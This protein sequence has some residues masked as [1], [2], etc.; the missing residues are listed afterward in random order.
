VARIS[1]WGCRQG[2]TVICEVGAGIW[3]PSADEIR[4]ARFTNRGYT[5]RRNRL[6]TGAEDNMIPRES[7]KVSIDTQV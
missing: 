5:E 6:D 2:I 4:S 3:R 1:P 7:V